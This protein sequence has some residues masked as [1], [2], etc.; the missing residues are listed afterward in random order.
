[1][2]DDTWVL[3]V[4]EGASSSIESAGFSMAAST[5]FAGVLSGVSGVDEV[6]F[7]SSL[8]VFDESRDALEGGVPF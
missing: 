2:D 8:G 1:M 5:A 6:V 3:G 4:V 7:D